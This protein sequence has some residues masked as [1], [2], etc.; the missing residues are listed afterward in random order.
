MAGV[1]AFREPQK[2]VLEPL[3]AFGAS[4]LTYQTR[5]AAYRVSAGSFFQTN[6]FLTDKLVEIVTAGRSGSLALD[7]YAG[8]GPFSTALACDFRHIVSVEMSQTPAAD[9]KYSLPSNG[10]AVPTGTAL[11]LA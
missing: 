10:K 11:Y 4:E 8:V 6:R 1:A 2:G 7:L 3:V 9:L 5:T